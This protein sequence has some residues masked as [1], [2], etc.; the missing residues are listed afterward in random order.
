MEFQITL[1]TI[2]G[3]EF[4]GPQCFLYLP[5]EPSGT[6]MYVTNKGQLGFIF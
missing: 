2:P 6:N 4:K 1:F 3:M 5:D